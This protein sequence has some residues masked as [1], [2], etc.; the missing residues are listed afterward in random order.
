MGKHKVMCSEMGSQSE[1]ILRL[2]LMNPI[3]DCSIDE[4]IRNVE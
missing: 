3:P 4:Q 1:K 2:N